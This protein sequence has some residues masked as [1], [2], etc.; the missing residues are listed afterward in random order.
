MNAMD[1]KGFISLFRRSFDDWNRHNDGRMGAAL[2]FY[3]IGSISP[4]VILV[5]AIVSLV[6]NKNAA[7]AQLLTKVQ[8]LVGTQGR[9]TVQTILIYGHRTF[10]GVFS[11]VAGVVVLLLGASGVLQELRSGLN[12]IWESEA[13]VPSGIWGIV[14]ER[15]LSFGLVLSL[16]FVLLVSLIMSTALSAIAAYFSNLL[17]IPPMLLEGFKFLI[18]FAGIAL[19]MACILKYVPAARVDWRD[20]RV[21]A[22]VTALP[23]RWENGCWA[24]T[25]GCRALVRPMAQP[26]PWWFS[27]SGS[28][29]LR[30]SSIWA[31]SS[32]TCMRWPIAMLCNRCPRSMIRRPW[33]KSPSTSIERTVFRRLLQHP[34]SVLL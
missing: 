31:L 19:L 27:W 26:G 4:L 30:R 17:P 29:I 12:S 14:R 3:T 13:K 33:G 18:S 6:F 15:V 24:S 21:G 20:V 25:W 10:G 11:T 23:S 34:L 5:L 8:S 22:T 9:E 28:T 1:M 2:A 32:H 16:G 7:E